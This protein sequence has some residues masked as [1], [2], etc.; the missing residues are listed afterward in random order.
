ML[1]YTCNFSTCSRLRQEASLDYMSPCLN[2]K[3]EKKKIIGPR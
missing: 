1:A 2:K 3:K